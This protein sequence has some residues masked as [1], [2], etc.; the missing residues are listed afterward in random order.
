MNWLSAFSLVGVKNF[1]CWQKLVPACKVIN[2]FFVCM[3][4]PVHPF[5][6]ESNEDFRFWFYKLGP[7]L[8]ISHWQKYWFPSIRAP[9]NLLWEKWLYDIL[10]LSS[11]HLNSSCDLI[12]IFRICA[13]I[14]KQQA[15]KIHSFHLQY[16][17]DSVHPILMNNRKLFCKFLRRLEYLRKRLEYLRK[18][19]R[20]W[21]KFGPSQ[22]SGA[23]DIDVACEHCCGEP[24][25]D[26]DDNS[27]EILSELSWDL[28]EQCNYSD[29]WLISW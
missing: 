1:E 4:V 10:L 17:L 14:T 19:L 21:L 20:I 12:L 24:V 13:L 28:E 9:P 29:G 25:D 11:I 16:V 15:T 22:W 27:E 6:N 8:S 3:C 26:C 18:R 23:E 2:L 7:F 5:W